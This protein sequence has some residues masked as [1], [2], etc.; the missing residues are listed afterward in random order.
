MSN[1]QYTGKALE[2]EKD[3]FDMHQKMKEKALSLEK[4]GIPIHGP[5]S[6]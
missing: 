5:I 4:Q 2:I 1:T 6:Q 3:I